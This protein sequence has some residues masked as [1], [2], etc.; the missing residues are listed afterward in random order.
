LIV[1]IAGVFED[2]QVLFRRQQ[3]R[4]RL[5]LWRQRTP[6]HMRCAGIGLRLWRWSLDLA[7]IACGLWPHSW[8][9]RRLA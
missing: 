5:V 6:R 1:G 9:A 3:D 2:L 4:P 7:R 8:H